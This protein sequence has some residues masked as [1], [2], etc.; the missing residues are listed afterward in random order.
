MWF[1]LFLQEYHALHDAILGMHCPILRRL[2]T[3]ILTYTPSLLIASFLAMK[4]FLLQQLL[5]SNRLRILDAIIIQ[6]RLHAPPSIRDWNIRP[7]RVSQDIGSISATVHA[8][9]EECVLYENCILAM[10]R[11]CALSQS[12]MS[13]VPALWRFCVTL[14]MY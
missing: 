11:E 2:E 13:C 5:R 14:F 7:V 12:G 1:R 8:R 10:G 3:K 6:R 4:V 9:S